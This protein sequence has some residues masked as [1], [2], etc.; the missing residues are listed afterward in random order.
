MKLTK[1]FGLINC[2]AEEEVSP[3]FSESHQLSV[4]EGRPYVIRDV[5]GVAEVHQDPIALHVQ[6]C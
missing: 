1:V 4:F 5:L 2:R 3:G 6:G